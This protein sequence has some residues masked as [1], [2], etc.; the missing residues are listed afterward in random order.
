[1]AMVIVAA[2]SKQVSVFFIVVPPT[3]PTEQALRDMN[4][5][6]PAA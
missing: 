5:E 4:S 3:S 2:A 6:P 1:M